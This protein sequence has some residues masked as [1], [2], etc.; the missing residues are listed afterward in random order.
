[1]NL[2]RLKLVAITLA[3]LAIAFAF[4]GPGI[5][6][7]PTNALA[8]PNVGSLKTTEPTCIVVNGNVSY[9]AKTEVYLR[10]DNYD[11]GSYWVRVTSPS[12]DVLG[13]SPS[14]N[15]TVPASGTQCLQLWSV[16]N[17]Q[18]NGTQGYDDTPNSG[19]E[20][21][22]V[23]C[24][25][26]NFAGS[27]CKSD[28]FKVESVEP[29]VGIAKSDSVSGSITAGGT[30]NWVLTVTVTNG[31]TSA[32][33]SDT[34]PAGFIIGTVTDNAASID[35]NTSTQTVTCSLSA[36]PTGTYT[37]TIPVTAPGGTPTTNCK[38]YTNN[39]NISNGG[40]S[41]TQ[42]D[43]ASD[44]VTVLCPAQPDVAISKS[45]NTSHSVHAGGTFNWVLTITVTNG[46]ASA[47]VQDSVP[48]GFAIGNVTDNAASI[49]CNTSTQTVSCTLTSTPTGTYTVTIPVTAPD[50][51]PTSECDSFQNTASITVGGG[52]NGNNDS[53]S[54]SVTVTCPD[55]GVSKSDDTGG[56]IQ[57]GGSFNWLVGV[58][59]TNG[60]ASATIQ[61]T[62]P[63]NFIIGTPSAN[64]G[65]IN[66]GKL[67][68]VVTCSL[69]GTPTGNYTITIPVTAPSTTAP[70][71][72]TSHENDVSITA[73]GGTNANN[74]SASDS[75]T[76]TCPDVGLSKTNN[77]NG[78]V[79]AGGGFNWLLTISVTNG[80]A[81]ATVQDTVP[82]GFSIGTRH[83]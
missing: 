69:S 21:N 61:D 66:C 78:S 3:A 53:A 74:N 20:Y 55:V 26:S 83:C 68:Q 42:N 13:T 11:P 10:V 1:M 16:V 75:V 63:A 4:A 8:A 15:Y 39:A 9:Q 64:S 72:C 32:T 28:N 58:S 19:G 80:P 22:V 2:S 6:P 48:S 14:A 73:G 40:G 37:V 43:T 35:C 51:S 34:I 47:T 60:P 30:F 65:T 46:P 56:T 79:T 24:S 59:V 62:V 25:T 52:T 7:K 49:D 44:S 50:G 36:T 67:G 12:G 57:A 81:S 27:D 17:K 33:V 82:D 71:A 54:D 29:D 23:V 77:V 41:N 76:V 31:P 45:D 5:A 38:Q 18:S 70:D